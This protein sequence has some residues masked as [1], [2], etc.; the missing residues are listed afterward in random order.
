MPEQV[1]FTI[2]ELTQGTVHGTGVF[3]VLMQAVKSHLKGEFEAGRIRGTDYANAM[4][5]SIGQV[6]SESTQYATQRAKLEAELKI[7][8]A[9]LLDIKA[10]TKI[11]DVEFDIQEFNRDFKLPKELELMEKDLLLKENQ[12]ELGN[13][14]L[15]VKQSQIELA[16]K[17][18]LVKQ[19]QIDLGIKELV[20]KESQL[21]IA[22]KELL[23]KAEQLLITKYELQYKLPADVGLIIA[24]DELYTQKTIT[25]KAQVDKSVVGPGSVIDTNNKLL[26]E[27][28][29]V[30]LR[31]AEQT[32]AKMM[33]DTWNVRHSS[34]PEGNLETAPGLKLTDVDIGNAITRMNNGLAG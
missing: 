8:D 33:I 7:L 22:E 6:L 28:S 20:I 29:K 11:K 14:E 31:N 9:Q 1:S 2:N 32:A 34:D 21:R 12:L 25:E 10:G 27:Q 4:A 18:L 19:N 26:V 23:I 15:L 3:D 5:V 17:E 30:Y 13:K 24:Q 16:A